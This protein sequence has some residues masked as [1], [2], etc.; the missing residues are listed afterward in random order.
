[1]VREYSLTT[2]EGKRC[3]SRLAGSTVGQLDEVER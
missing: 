1:M 2:T 3:S